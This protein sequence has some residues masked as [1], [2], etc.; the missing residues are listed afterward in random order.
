M[1]C[2][3]SDRAI[4]GVD[5]TNQGGWRQTIMNAKSNERLTRNVLLNRGYSPIRVFC[6]V[7]TCILATIVVGLVFVY[8]S[9]EYD[10]YIVKSESMEPAID[11]GDMIIT[12]PVGGPFS[13]E[14]KPGVIVSYQAGKSLVTHRVLSFDNDT[15]VTKGD[16]VEDP[17]PQ[18]VP[19]SQVMGLYLFKI[20][21]LG[22]LSY[23][24]HTKLG[25]FLL[26]ILPATTLVAFIV[27]EI[28]KEAPSSTHV[29]ARRK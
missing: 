4:H 12:G 27:K 20:P 7:V 24:I 22:Y 6:W 1:R 14:I 3:E 11:M 2:K 28:I 29:A 8:L 5:D 19:T 10:M 16:A 18:P 23:F 9:P 17:D 21:K 25:W 15:L 26:I 13:H